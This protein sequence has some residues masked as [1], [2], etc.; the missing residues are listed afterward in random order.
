MLEST[1]PEEGVSATDI[2]FN[3]IY[4]NIADKMLSCHE[5][6]SVWFDNSLN[7]C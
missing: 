7:L 1:F 4:T 5:V 6:E 2:N 3:E